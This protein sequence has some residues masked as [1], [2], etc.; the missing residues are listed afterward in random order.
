M[1]SRFFEKPSEPLS[2]SLMRYPVCATKLPSQRVMERLFRGVVIRQFACG[3]IDLGFQHDFEFNGK[4]FFEPA[5]LIQGI[6][7][8]KMKVTVTVDSSFNVNSKAYSS[9]PKGFLLNDNGSGSLDLARNEVGSWFLGRVEAFRAKYKID[10]LR[11]CCGQI[12]FPIDRYGLG[13]GQNPGRIV[14]N[15]ARVAAK[16]SKSSDIEVGY[17]T[18]SL[19]LVIKIV[20]RNPEWGREMGLRSL[21][22]MVLSV[23]ISGYPFVTIGPIGGVSYGDSKPERELYIRWMQLSAFFPMMEFRIYP[24]EY[25]DETTQISAEILDIRSMLWDNILTIA[26][27]SVDTGAPVIRPLWW[28]SPSDPKTYSLSSQFM[29]GDIYLVAPVLWSGK[30][31][32]DVYLPKGVWRE[33]FGKGSKREI[34]VG[35]WIT[36][37]VDLKT[38]VYFEC[39]LCKN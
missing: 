24:W 18:Q 36:L 4:E 11:F 29:L 13:K 39:L 38:V 25:D 31:K 17:K 12:E 20:D 33:M 27:Q 34:E 23:G 26:K 7:Q 14:Q 35:R 2:K 1:A 37:D 10:T 32:H 6:Q 22:P 3:H 8:K 9:V 19:P 30:L 28:I 16:I 15:Y 21:I 5:S